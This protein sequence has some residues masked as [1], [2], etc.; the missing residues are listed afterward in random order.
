MTTEKEKVI[1][2]K[3]HTHWW[4]YNHTPHQFIEKSS[5]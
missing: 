2:G 4:K 1:R 3:N 5:H